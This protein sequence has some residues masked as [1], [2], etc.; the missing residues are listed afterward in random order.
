MASFYDVKVIWK[1][2]KP[3]QGRGIGNNAAWLCSCGEILL[4]PHEDLFS[5]DPCPKCGVSFRVIRGTP[6]QFVDHVR[7]I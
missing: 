6:P 7:E 2:K 4:G 3:T 5:V 1:T